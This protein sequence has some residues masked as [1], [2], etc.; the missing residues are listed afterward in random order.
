MFINFLRNFQK[1]F[2]K[3]LQHFTDAKGKEKGKD[4]PN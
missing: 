1:V 2:Q 4:V 3:K